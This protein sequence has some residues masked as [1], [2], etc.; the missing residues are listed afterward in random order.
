MAA[1]EFIVGHAADMGEALVQGQGGGWR[2]GEIGHAQEAFLVGKA[3]TE[4][5]GHNVLLQRLMRPL[6]SILLENGCQGDAV[7]KTWI[8]CAVTLMFCGCATD[9]FDVNLYGLRYHDDAA[10]EV[11]EL[12]EA[13]TPASMPDAD[14]RA[15]ILPF[16]LRQDI[17]VRKDVGREMAD[18]FRLAW[19]QKRIFGTM[20]YDSSQPWP[21]LAEA[22]D[23]ARAKG[24]NILVSGNVSQYFEGSGTGR[25]SIGVTVEIHWV[26]DGTLIWSAAQSAAMEAGPD[27]DYVV[28]RST[29]RLP[30]HPT[31]AVMRALAASMAEGFA[32][33]IQ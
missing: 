4:W 7:M 13:V 9:P 5:D 23:Q 21:G 33:H 19:L 17:A 1:H 12:V 29:R 10:V 18:I 2:R 22:M 26:P 27:K 32:L 11:S 3:I 25:T 14:L 24:A 20:E 31:Y 16:A 28:V 6:V 8:L 15:L 30:E